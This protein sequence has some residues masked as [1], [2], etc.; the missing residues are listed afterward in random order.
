[1]QLDVT[2]LHKHSF[3]PSVAS[4]STLRQELADA[5]I[6]IH[7]KRP[8]QLVSTE[9]PSFPLFRNAALEG[10][11]PYEGTVV[12]TQGEKVKRYSV[13]RPFTLVTIEGFDINVRVKDIPDPPNILYSKNY[14]DLSQDWT[15]DDGPGTIVLNETKIPLC[16]WDK[17]YKKHRPQVWEQWKGRW[18]NWRVWHCIM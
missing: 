8:G 14:Q 5:E 2:Y 6:A 13:S 3:A 18:R 11:L 7:Q 12:A 1:M 4:S 9:T 15:S 16:G 17:V 10:I